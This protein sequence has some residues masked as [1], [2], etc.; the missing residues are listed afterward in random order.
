MNGV[1]V[2]GS[3][4]AVQG[5]PAGVG[6]ERRGLVQRGLEPAGE[7]LEGSGIRPRHARRRHE[8][9]AHFTNHLLR[10][11]RG[12]VRMR[13]VQFRQRHAA[14]MNFAVMAVNAILVDQGRRRRARLRVDHAQPK[15]RRNA[16]PSIH[17]DES[18]LTPRGG[19]QARSG[20]L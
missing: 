5:G 3:V 8:A 15:Q 17:A 2:F 20:R 9:G 12:L 16:T 7:A 13:D 19:S 18:V 10:Q 6:I 11:F 14:R 4:Q 1:G